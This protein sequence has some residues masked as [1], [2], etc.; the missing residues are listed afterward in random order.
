MSKNVPLS[1]YLDQMRQ[2]LVGHVSADDFTAEYIATFK[3]D[4]TM[5]VGELFDVLNGIYR[6]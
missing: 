5:Y 2:L 1:A 4:E 6:L 3:A